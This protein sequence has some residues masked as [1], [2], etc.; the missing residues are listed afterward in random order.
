MLNEL[1]SK[2]GSFENFS[3]VKLIENWYLKIG[4]LYDSFPSSFHH[5]VTDVFS[6]I[7]KKIPSLVREPPPGQPQARRIPFY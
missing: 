2:R 5:V 1:K 7:L 6:R 4:N 3:I